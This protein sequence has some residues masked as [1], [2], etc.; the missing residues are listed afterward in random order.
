MWGFVVL[1]AIAG[2]VALALPPVHANLAWAGAT[3][4]D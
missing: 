2:A 1:A 4:D 3:S